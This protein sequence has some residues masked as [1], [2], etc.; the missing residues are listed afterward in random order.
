MMAT[1][2]LNIHECDV[3]MVGSMGAPGDII[4]E[5]MGTGAKHLSDGPLAIPHGEVAVRQMSAP[6][7]KFDELTAVLRDGADRLGT[8]SVA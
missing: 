5:A 6:E 7:S 1:G 3:F 2:H 8:G 4:G